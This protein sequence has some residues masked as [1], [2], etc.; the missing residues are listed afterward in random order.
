MKSD[1]WF[2]QIPLYGVFLFSV[3]GVLVCIWAGTALGKWRRNMPDH[4]EESSLGTIISATLGLLAFL[5]AFTFGM[6]ADRFQTRKELLLN[7][8][9]IISTTYLRAGLLLEPHRTELRRL[10]TEYVDMRVKLSQDISERQMNKLPEIIA[11]AESLQNQMWLHAVAMADRER[12][13]EID[14]LFIDSLNELFDIHT[15]RLTVF[16]YHIPETIWMVLFFITIF[17]MG[18][19]GYQV[20]LSGK[21]VFKVSVVLAMVFSSVIFLIADLDRSSEGYLRVS[22][23]PMIELQQKMHSSSDKPQAYMGYNRDRAK[24]PLGA[25]NCILDI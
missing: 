6:A 13:S 10:L 7:E 9:N 21:N 20:G 14:A 22:Q 12:S 8:V 23:L 16:R 17:S 5:L 4:E 11:L 18:T 1:F 15:S 2:D 24:T 19:V 25:K 3:V